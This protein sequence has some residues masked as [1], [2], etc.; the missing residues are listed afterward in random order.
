MI[1]W[2]NRLIVILSIVVLTFVVGK[3]NA[4][5]APAE[6]DQIRSA[7]DI[8]GVFTYCGEPAEGINVFIPG[9]SFF[10]ITGPSGDYRLSY[11][12]SGT[13]NII[14]AKSSRRLYVVSDVSVI[15]RAVVTVTTP[16]DLCLDLDGDGVKGDRDCDDSNARVYPDSAE[17]CFDGVDNNCNGLAEEGCPECVDVD[18]DGYYAQLGC[19]T[20]VDCDDSQS[21]IHPGAAELCGDQADNNCDGEVDESSAVDALSFYQD[22]DGDGFGA[23]DTDAVRGCEPPAGYTLTGGDCDDT[24]SS[25]YPG[26]PEICNGGDDD[27]DGVVDNDCSNQLCT[28]E[29]VAIFDSCVGSCGWSDTNCLV[30]CVDAYQGSLSTLCTD[31]IVALGS[32]SFG[33]QGAE[34]PDVCSYQQCTTEW[35]AVFGS[36]VPTECSDG[37]SRPCGSSNV[38]PCSFGT[39]TCSNGYWGECVG[40]T[41]P[42]QET[43]NGI[44]DDCNGAVDDNAVDGTTYYFDSDR[45]GFG[46]AVATIQACSAPDGYTINGDDCNDNNAQVF[47]G[48]TAYFT[49]PADGNFDYDCNRQEELELTD[50]WEA[51]LDLTSCTLISDGWDYPATPIPDCGQSGYYLT[52]A[53][54][55]VDVTGPYCAP[56]ST[57]IRTQACR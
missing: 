8:V 9:S 11:V 7:G 56:E 23:V 18:G 20:P 52:G 26:A 54:F 36:R 49:V 21:A 6:N 30:Q 4:V 51:S 2:R 15:K 1:R 10:A 48:Q 32:C 28:P 41:D 55:G 24:A 13:Y 34:Y 31:A 57:S 3:G 43:C 29:E 16:P 27:C 53:T 45:D 50:V 46:D 22:A 40:A 47:P 14:F 39:Q 42:T 12:P 44:D 5:A 19:G 25:V 37:D 17:I 33:C 35:Q 38:A